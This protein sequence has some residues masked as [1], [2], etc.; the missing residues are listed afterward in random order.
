M[1]GLETI[2]FTAI[3]WLF[4]KEVHR[5]Q[6]QQA[7]RRADMM[8]HMAMNSMQT[9]ANEAKRADMEKMK[10]KMLGKGVMDYAHDP[11]MQP[12]VAMVHTLY[13]EMSEEA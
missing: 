9:V 13:P 10:G 12:L 1:S 2:T 7:E 4:G 11:G 5:Q 8:G 3:G 6:A